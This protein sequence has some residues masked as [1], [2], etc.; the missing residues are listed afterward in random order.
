MLNAYDVPPV[1]CIFIEDGEQD[2][3]FGAKSFGEVAIV[4]V[5]PAVVAAVNHALGTNLS[6]LPLNPTAILTA[7]HEE[8]KR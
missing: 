6:A 4:P 7:L 5:T 2:G 1:E 8:G 3:P